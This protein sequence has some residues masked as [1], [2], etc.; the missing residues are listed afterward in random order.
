MATLKLK[1]IESIFAL[2]VHQ[3]LER[4]ENRVES[5]IQANYTA[6]HPTVAWRFRDAAIGM[7]EREKERGTAEP[8]SVVFSGLYP[9]YGSADIRGSSRHRSAAVRDDLIEHLAGD[10]AAIGAAFC[11]DHHRAGGIALGSVFDHVLPFTGRRGSGH[12]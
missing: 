7:I 3:N 2:A 4:F 6:I 11:V 12:L 9:L 1:Q 5:I 8:E 10:L